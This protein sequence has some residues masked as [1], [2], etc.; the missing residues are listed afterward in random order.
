[1]AAPNPGSPK[2]VTRLLL[3]VRYNLKLLGFNP[4]R[5]ISLEVKANSEIRGCVNKIL[6]PLNS[7]RGSATPRAGAVPPDRL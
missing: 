5:L 1:L 3:D 6:C 2:F 4:L 7:L